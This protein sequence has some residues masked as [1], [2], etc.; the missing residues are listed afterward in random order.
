MKLHEAQLASRIDAR[1]IPEGVKGAVVKNRTE[2]ALLSHELS[3]QR[4]IFQSGSWSIGLA[5]TAWHK[6]ML[7]D[8]PKIGCST[9]QAGRHDFDIVIMDEAS[10]L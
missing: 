4:A 10:Q 7:H 2:L 6:A 8:E 9:P 1:H 5:A 3:K